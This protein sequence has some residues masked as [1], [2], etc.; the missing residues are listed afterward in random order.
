MNRCAE[1]ASSVR[2]HDLA[3]RLAG[4]EFIVLFNDADETT[5]GEIVTRIQDAVASFNWGAIASGLRVSLSIG[6]SQA[7]AGDTV[8]SIVHRSDKSMYSD[9]ARARWEPTRV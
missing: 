5:A 6:L 4:D 9:K 1:L 8:E 2:E 7:A 3:A